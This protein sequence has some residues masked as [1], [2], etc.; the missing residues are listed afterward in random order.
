MGKNRDRLSIV[1]AILETANSG[2]TKSHIKIGANLSF[3][4]L[5]KYLNIVVGAGF[6][7]VEGCTF[8]LTARGREFLKQY[9]HFCERYVEARKLFE[10]LRSDWKRLSLM[11]GDS[12]L[13]ISHVRPVNSVE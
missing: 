7:R 1:A 9:K 12:G 8:E 13:P 4:L 11:C 2:A 6:V 3:S 10:A 5:E